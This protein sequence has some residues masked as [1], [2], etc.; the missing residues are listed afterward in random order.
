MP[1]RQGMEC[2]R[3]SERFIGFM[4]SRLRVKR[5]VATREE[6]FFA[7]ASVYACVLYARH[8]REIFSG[9]KVGMT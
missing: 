6:T 5:W 8:I 9:G 4:Q 2:G 7:E 1:E 3:T